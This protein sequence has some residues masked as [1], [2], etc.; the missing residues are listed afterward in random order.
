L[1]KKQGAKRKRR[2]AQARAKRNPSPPT[3][4]GSLLAALATALNTCEQAGVRVSLKHG[5]L[6]SR[7][8]VVLPPGKKKLWEARVFGMLPVSPPE[9]EAG[10]GMDD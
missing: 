7:Y 6:F 4:P 8:G 2:K 5:A 3:E 1:S 10:D 9:D